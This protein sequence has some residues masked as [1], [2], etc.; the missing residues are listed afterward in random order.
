MNYKDKLN[1]DTIKIKI[2]IIK[3]RIRCMKIK[4]RCL[5]SYLQND[6]LIKHYL[7]KHPAVETQKTQKRET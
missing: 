6:C 3:I 4:L 2:R 1:K 7:I 5:N